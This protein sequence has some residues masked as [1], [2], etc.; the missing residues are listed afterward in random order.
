MFFCNFVFSLCLV[1]QLFVRLRYCCQLFSLDICFLCG[2]QVNGT[3]LN[4]TNLSVVIL[5]ISQVSCINVVLSSFPLKKC[6]FDTCLLIE[7]LLLLI[8]LLSSQL[9]CHF[10]TLLGSS[11]STLNS[12]RYCLIAT[13]KTSK[14]D[15]CLVCFLKFWYLQLRSSRCFCLQVGNAL[16]SGKNSRS[17]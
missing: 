11:N 6:L 10:C 7:G 3:L 14:E 5:H 17:I 1:N 16:L 2:Q 4:I 12:L 9:V 8:K 13:N 15:K